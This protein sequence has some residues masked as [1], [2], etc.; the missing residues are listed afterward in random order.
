MEYLPGDLGAMMKDHNISEN[1]TKMVTKQI[2]AGLEIM[3]ERNICH[4]DLK[5]GNILIAKWIPLTVKIAD[6]GVSKSLDGTQGRTT[7]GTKPFMAP[8]IW[9]FGQSSSSAYTTAVDLWSLGCL[10][11]YMMTKRVPFPDT[12]NLINF[13]QGLETFPPNSREA[14]NLSVLAVAFMAS[15]L[16]TNP[17]DRSTASKAQ[18]HTWLIIKDDTPTIWTMLPS[19]PR[20]APPPIHIS[21]QSAAQEVARSPHN[22]AKPVLDLVSPGPAFSNGSAV[23][24]ATPTPLL[25]PANDSDPDYKGERGLKVPRHRVRR[26]VSP[27]PGGM[28]R[29]F[30]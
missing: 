3:H 6:F 9:G 14:S 21:G 25:D 13:V 17:Q 24:L 19:A 11:Y 29:S 23:E 30:I 22:I 12:R 5:P 16:R 7:T 10:V 18:L 26:S 15:L 4:R 8:E 20:A 1:E 27:A 2:L 28:E